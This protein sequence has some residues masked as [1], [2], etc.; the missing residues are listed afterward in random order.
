[1]TTTTPTP[2]DSEA[3]RLP[4]HP[5]DRALPRTLRRHG[6]RIVLLVLA[7][8]LAASTAYLALQQQDRE[9]GAARAD[10]LTAARA[11]ALDAAR[12]HAETIA[13]YD[14]RELDAY[15]AAVHDLATGDFAQQYDDANQNLRSVLRKTEATVT[16]EVIDAAVQTVTEDHAVV[17]L[18]VDQE[19]QN[20]A[21]NGTATDR[22]RMR[23]TLERH[24]ERWLV[25]DLELR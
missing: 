25:S 5:R 1:M 10:A 2:T 11:D 8:A 22:N 24:G 6:P 4:V 18:F 7:L 13:S 15:F 16:A 21:T 23:M 3:A 12:A 17:L 20:V 14:Y 19:V 9:R